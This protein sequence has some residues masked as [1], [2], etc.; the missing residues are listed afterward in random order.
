L[1]APLS[2]MLLKAEGIVGALATAAKKSATLKT[3]K[4]SIVAPV[5]L[6]L[7]MLVLFVLYALPSEYGAL[8]ARMGLDPAKP[9]T[10]KTILEA[11]ADERSNAGT[12]IW[13]STGGDFFSYITVTSRPLVRALLEQS[14]IDM[15]QILQSGVGTAVILALYALIPGLAGLIY[16]RQ[17]L[18]WFL[19]GFGLLLLINMSGMFP[20]LGANAAYMPA[21]GQVLLFL[22][23]QVL[24]L[25][26]AFRLRRR[27][28]GQ[29][30]IPAV[31]FNWGLAALL[32]LVG[33]ACWQGWGP[34]AGV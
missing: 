34:G 29:P 19:S 30:M 20:A 28:A 4:G 25:V 3:R 16:R 21:S 24:L 2:L 32:T 27:S 11:F 17:F 23:S 6:L 9:A 13:E 33:I 5:L 22:A 15:K 18:P 31:Y 10:A 14:V 8:A 12:R 7:L 26:L 1:L